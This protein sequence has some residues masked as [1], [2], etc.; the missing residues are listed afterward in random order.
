[1]KAAGRRGS[2]ARG[3]G[4]AG[5]AVSGSRIGGVSDDPRRGED[6]ELGLPGC[7]GEDPPAGG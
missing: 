1:M 6:G 3:Q 7:G 4:C 2:E 5:T